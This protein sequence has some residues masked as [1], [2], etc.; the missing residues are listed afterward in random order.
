MKLAFSKGSTGCYN[1][2]GRGEA[3][4]YYQNLTPLAVDISIEFLP[5]LIYFGIVPVS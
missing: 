2:G 5:L 3:T 4:S 1:Q